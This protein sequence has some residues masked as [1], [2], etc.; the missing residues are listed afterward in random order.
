[1]KCVTRFRR[2]NGFASNQAIRQIIDFTGCFQKVKI[3]DDFEIGRADEFNEQL[4]IINDE[5]AQAVGAAFVELI[6]FHG[7][8]H[9]AEDFRPENI[10]ETVAAFL[11]QPKKK[12]AACLVLADKSGKSLF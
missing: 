3:F 1:M 7:G 6:A 5:I 10:G 12:F 8:E 2:R 9:G 4:L 11:G